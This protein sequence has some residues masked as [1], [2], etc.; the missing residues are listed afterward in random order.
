MTRD[1]KAAILSLAA[2]FAIGAIVVPVASAQFESEAES[3]TV[4]TTLNE[5]QEFRLNVNSEGSALGCTSVKP[6]KSTVAGKAV[7][8]VSVEP[9]YNACENFLGQ[10]VSVSANECRYVFALAKGSTSGSVSV[11]C[12]AGKAI[13]IKVGSICRYTIGTQIG[14]TGSITYRNVNNTGEPQHREIEVEPAVGGITSARVTNDFP[15]LCPN[16]S[17]EGSYRG[18]AIVRGVSGTQVGI[19]VD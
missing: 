19:F 12:E 17:T 8:T 9:E 3:T 4:F 13:E 2:A 16:G 1:L 6:N 5:V 15:F 10:S 11:E 18:N 14:L 7:T